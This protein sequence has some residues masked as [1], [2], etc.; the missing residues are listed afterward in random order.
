MQV[1]KQE[2]PGSANNSK[3]L[4]LADITR[5]CGIFQVLRLATVI[6]SEPVFQTYS[7]HAFSTTF[8]LFVTPI[9]TYWHRQ[10]LTDL[11]ILI[12]KINISQI[13]CL[14]SFIILRIVVKYT[15]NKF[16]LR[17]NILN[18]LYLLVFLHGA[19]FLAVNYS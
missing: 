6:K 12:M 18:W 3:Y 7:N 9:P 15:I 17:I 8:H 16:D 2:I 13:V 19:H 14:I 4:K 10:Y 1:L 5:H 11:Y